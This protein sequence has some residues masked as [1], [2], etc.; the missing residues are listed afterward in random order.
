[1][2]FYEDQGT[3]YGNDH[4]DDNFPRTRFILDRLRQNDRV[5]EFGCQT[6]GI[7][8]SIA[9]SPL[10][11]ELHAVEVSRTYLERAKVILQGLPVALHYGFAEDFFQLPKFD[12]VI[13]MEIIE[14][15]KDPDVLLEA[16]KRNLMS[17][18]AALL[19]VPKEDYVDT[20]NEHVRE[21]T[22]D[23][24]REL[25]EKHFTRIIITEPEGEWYLAEVRY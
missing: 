9:K 6:G 12:V 20:I 15:V 5:L 18:G 4:L 21:F 7:T 25:L 8:R 11:K 13:A 17:T 22:K 14:H 23:S 16:V 10:V 3:K 1:M 2:E 24:F 19:S